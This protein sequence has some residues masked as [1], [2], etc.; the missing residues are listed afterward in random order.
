MVNYI[1]LRNSSYLLGHVQ[2][3]S[4]AF[5][6]D[7]SWTLCWY[8]LYKSIGEVLFGKSYNAMILIS[9]KKFEFVNTNHLVICKCLVIH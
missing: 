3:T 7:D 5:I 2:A 4:L 9:L 1:A 6:H 8:L